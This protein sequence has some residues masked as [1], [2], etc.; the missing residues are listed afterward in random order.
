MAPSDISRI[1][2]RID[3][4]ANEFHVAVAQLATNRED[5]LNK[6]GEVVSAVREN[7]A[8][9]GQCLPIVLGN[10]RP[11]LSV[12]LVKLEEFRRVTARIFWL[13]VGTLSSATAYGL[14]YAIQR[15]L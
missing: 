7:K 15:S 10:G 4:L 11:P 12:R 13:V 5:I 14:W 3:N 6:I 8:L 1:H 2:D 9:C